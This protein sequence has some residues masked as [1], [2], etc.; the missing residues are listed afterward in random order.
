MDTEG[1]GSGGGG[2]TFG[3][4]VPGCRRADFCFLMLLLLLL[5]QGRVCSQRGRA[6]LRNSHTQKKKER[7]KKQKK[8]KNQLMAERRPSE[9]NALEPTSR[10]MMQVNAELGLGAQTQQ[11]AD[12]LPA[13]PCL[14]CCWRSTWPAPFAGG[15]PGRP[16]TLNIRCQVLSQPSR[17]AKPV[18]DGKNSSPY[19][20]VSR[21]TSQL[22]D[23]SF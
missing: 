5:A 1:P 18:H 13:G 22:M 15:E 8:L 19:L 20:S 21:Q 16:G 12:H 23:G 14:S 2:E 3:L 9:S 10:E 17:G 11:A 7:K 4:L 6:R